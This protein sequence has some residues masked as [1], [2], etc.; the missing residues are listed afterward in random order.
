LRQVDAAGFIWNVYHP[1]LRDKLERGI[2]NVLIT[3]K[4]N[5]G[6]GL[7]E[8]PSRKAPLKWTDHLA[9][10]LHKLV[11]KKFRKGGFTL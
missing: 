5:L 4:V 6:L 2:V 10:E 9:V 3:S 8:K 7:K 11:I 1:S